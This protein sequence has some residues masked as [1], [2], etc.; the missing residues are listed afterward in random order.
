MLRLETLPARYGDCIWIEY[1]TDPIRRILI[2]GGLSLTL[3][4][5]TI[6]MLADLHKD[7]EQ[8]CEDIKITPEAVE[9]ARK[10]GPFETLGAAPWPQ[11]PDVEQLL[12]EDFEEDNSAAN[13]SSIAFLLESRLIRILLAAD[14]HPSTLVESIG[15]LGEGKF[16]LDA[17]KLAHH[18]SRGSVSADRSTRFLRAHETAPVRQ[19]VGK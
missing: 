7:W 15:R 8:S 13:A 2:D 18:G 19:G 1:G 10:E 17:F 4:S 5:P 6:P 12:R 3:L 11:R 14:A 9:E 16:K